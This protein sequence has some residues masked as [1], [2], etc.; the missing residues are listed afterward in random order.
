MSV[1]RCVREEENSLC[2]YI[3]IFKKSSSRKLMQLRQSIL[4]I[5]YRVENL[6]NRKRKNLNKT[7]KKRKFM[8]SLSGKF[9]RKL[10]RIRIGNGYP[11]M[12]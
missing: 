9:Q 4:K 10:T 8:D 7:G 1:E 6:K 11:K 5:L 3:A 12:I 2:F